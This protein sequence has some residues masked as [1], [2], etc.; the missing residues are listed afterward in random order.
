[1]AFDL[2]KTNETRYRD[3]GDYGVRVARPGFD[4]SR[5]AENQ[6][7]F[8]SAWPIIQIVKILF[9]GKLSSTEIVYYD[10]FAGQ[11]LASKPDW[12]PDPT[13]ERPVLP[14]DI[15]VSTE[16]TT[17]ASGKWWFYRTTVKNYYRWGDNRASVSA[18][19]IEKWYH[20][21]GY[22]PMFVPGRYVSNIELN[23]DDEVPED[24]KKYWGS[25][26]LFPVDLS[27]DVDYPYTEE[28][29]P[30]IGNTGDYGMTSLSE[31]SNVPG[32][33]SNMFSKL[34]QCVKTTD[35]SRF[36]VYSD[37]AQT[38]IEEKLLLWSPLKQVVSG[39]EKC[40][41]PYEALVFNA[42]DN[43]FVGFMGNDGIYSI[44]YGTDGPYY[45]NQSYVTTM[46]VDENPANYSNA[47]A[48]TN[49]GQ[50]TWG[51]KTASMVVLRSPMVS[52]DY[53]EIVI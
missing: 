45:T 12:V 32:L 20:G 26:L 43:P 27:T 33:C 18:A 1:M 39:Y 4:A 9:P 41:M 42:Y 7:I 8:N 35:T 21:L 37:A 2:E 30:L 47:V 25:V 53:E 6:L 29:L 22:Q 38:Q 5:C 10:D 40:L 46:G 36:F 34:V 24:Q 50:T 17:Y 14:E 19:I 31:Y 15:V 11:V 51:Y 52:P 28:A 49:R 23:E 16:G 3:R 44:K 13:I 48:L